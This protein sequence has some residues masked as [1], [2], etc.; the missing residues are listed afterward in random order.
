L[1]QFK[2]AIIGAGPAGY[3]TAQAFQNA[4]T[5]SM[6]FSIDLFER[7]PTPWGLVRSGVAPDHQKIKSVSKVFEKI[8][9]AQNFRFFGNVEV[10][11]D[12]S[13]KELQDKYDVVVLATG[14]S[15]G[16]K[17][18][19]PGEN[20]KNSFTAA[21]FV[22][23]YNSHPDFSSLDIDLSCDTAV[24]IGAGN[25]AIDI[26][27]IL[28]K[29]PNEL[30]ATDIAEYALTKLANSKI[31]KV[32]ILARRGPTHAAFTSIELRE[33]LKL[34]NVQFQIDYSLI[35]DSFSLIS[36]NEITDKE[37]I[38]NIRLMK[39][40]LDTPV[41]DANKTLEIRFNSSPIEIVGANSVEQVRYVKNNFQN[42]EL[43]DRTEKF[44]I[45]TGII[46]SAIGYEPA[47]LDGVSISNGK[48]N[49]IAGHIE[50]N[51]YTTGWAKRGS[52]GVIGTNKSDSL[53]VVNLIISKLSKPKRT[54]DATKLFK[55]IEF[56]VDQTGWE[57]INAVEMVAGQTINKPRVKIFERAD[58]L[59]ICSN[60]SKQ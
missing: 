39:Q 38:A 45:K 34:G 1:N 54:E 19:I 22:S 10:G 16:K 21:E 12:I 28:I 2:V 50:Q 55:K 42:L 60:L 11:K 41:I 17:L 35:E 52:S 23:W 44:S 29:D 13:L 32:I 40:L 57:K 24:I 8:A 26:A 6:S 15:I 33:L 48:V 18:R 47:K 5:E 51:L 30:K 36:N 14:T 20:I 7:L 59:K 3:F 25:V 46:I 43:D 56:I 4:Q 31:K 37:V 49:N 58:F 9:K 53:D 27:R